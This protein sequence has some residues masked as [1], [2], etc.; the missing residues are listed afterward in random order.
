MQ[1]QQVIPM[2]QRRI[3]TLMQ[4]SPSRVDETYSRAI[5]VTTRPRAAIFE[6]SRSGEPGDL[7]S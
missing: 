4:A 7:T 5:V 1:A 3:C 6:M 2:D